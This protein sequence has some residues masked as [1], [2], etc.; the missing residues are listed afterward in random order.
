[1]NIYRKDGYIM[2]VEE[3]VNLMSDEAYE[4]LKEVV[5]VKPNIDISKKSANDI[6]MGALCKAV[7]EDVIHVESLDDKIIKL[8]N[9]PTNTLSQSKL[10]YVLNVVHE[11]QPRI[12]C[13]ITIM[14]S[15]MKDTLFEVEYHQPDAI[16]FMVILK[17]LIDKF[18]ITPTKVRSQMNA[19]KPTIVNN[20]AQLVSRVLNGN[21]EGVT[22]SISTITRLV[23]C[24]DHLIYAKFE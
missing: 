3:A 9:S 2:T 23:N 13:I 19:L 1:M 11:T 7:L 4:K 10:K 17:W 14:T 6:L 18:D 12:K 20:I 8:L 21:L 24:N 16:D 5:T 15:D 22:V